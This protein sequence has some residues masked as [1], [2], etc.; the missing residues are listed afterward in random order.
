MIFTDRARPTGGDGARRQTQPPTLS[1]LTR[2]PARPLVSTSMRGED[3]PSG[4]AHFTHAARPAPTP[5]R[6]TPARPA[7]ARPTPA[8]PAPVDQSLLDQPLLDQPLLDQP[9][10]DQPLLDQPLLDQPLL[11]QPLLDQPL[12]DQT[13][14]YSTKKGSGMYQISVLSSFHMIN[15]SPITC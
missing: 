15:M 8:R 10:L 9:L 13:R 5:A 14:P 2:P 12:L 3:G 1:G 4:H 11:D 7:P 6:P